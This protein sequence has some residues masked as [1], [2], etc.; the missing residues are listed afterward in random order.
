MNRQSGL[1]RSITHGSEHRQRVRRSKWRSLGLL[2]LFDVL[3]V[4][5]VVLSFQKTE[6]VQ[7]EVELRQ[8]REVYD[9]Q[10][11]Q[12]VITHTVIVTEIVP[13]GSIQ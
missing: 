1:P 12:Q 10:V 13:N 9:V 11:H 8:T 3:L 5:M 4:V 6:L 7:E 2:I